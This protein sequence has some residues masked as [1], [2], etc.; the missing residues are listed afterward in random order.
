Q[1]LGDFAHARRKNG[2]NGEFMITVVCGLIGSGKSTWARQH[3]DIVTECEDHDKDR[4]IRETLRFDRSG[5]DVCHITC[6][7]TMN[8]EWAF[9]DKKV[10]YLWINTDPS[11]SMKNVIARGRE[12][13]L[14]DLDRVERKNKELFQKLSASGFEEIEVFKTTERW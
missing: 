7:P 4:Q 5:K 6:F 13:D 1:D 11:Q 12:R 2:K 3:F 8:E 14:I 9:Q 10:R